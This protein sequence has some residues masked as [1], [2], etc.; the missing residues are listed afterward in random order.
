[1]LQRFFKMG[2]YLQFILHFVLMFAFTFC[3]QTRGMMEIYL[4][5]NCSIDQGRLMN[6]EDIRNNHEDIMERLHDEQFARISGG[7]RISLN[8][9]FELCVKGPGNF[10]GTKYKLVDK[11]SLFKCTTTCF[12]NQKQFSGVSREDC[13][14]LE[15]R[16]RDCTELDCTN[17]HEALFYNNSTKL[18]DDTLKVYSFR[19]DNYEPKD[20]IQKEAFKQCRY[21]KK[22]EKTWKTIYQSCSSVNVKGFICHTSSSQRNCTEKNERSVNEKGL[23]FCVVN[24]R[25]SFLEAERYCPLKGGILLDTPSK[26]VIKHLDKESLY[27]LNSFREFQIDYNQRDQLGQCIFVRKSNNELLIETDKCDKSTTSI[28]TKRLDPTE[29]DHHITTETEMISTKSYAEKN[30]EGDEHDS[31]FAKTEFSSTTSQTEASYIGNDNTTTEGSGLSDQT[32][33]T[34]HNHTQSDIEDSTEKEKENGILENKSGVLIIGVSVGLIL[35]VGILVTLVKILAVYRSHSRQNTNKNVQEDTKLH[36]SYSNRE[37]L[38]QESDIPQYEGAYSYPNTDMNQLQGSENGSHYDIIGRT[39]DDI[40]NPYNDSNKL[41]NLGSGSN[42]DFIGQ[43]NDENVS[44]PTG[45]QSNI[46]NTTCQDSSDYDKLG[47]RVNISSG[48]AE[49]SDVYN[50]VFSDSSLEYDTCV[51][52][53]VQ[54]SETA[55]IYNTVS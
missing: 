22:H 2:M 25:M 19:A 32:T 11:L 52:R 45:Q 46:Y 10:F 24:E 20:P 8:I 47:Q 51:K 38:A 27:L 7:P 16:C 14:C 6:Y 21:V 35:L 12:H 28:C 3:I 44:N 5:N 31:T 41:Q 36:V 34:A 18:K 29:N 26:E 42:Y 13:Y 40:P 30:E 4:N 50:H 15:K 1:M 55:Q 53:S 54:T 23:A 33:K 48:C 39:N 49:S 37:R 17:E 43:T 9:K